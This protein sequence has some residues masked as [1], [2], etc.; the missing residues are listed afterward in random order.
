[1]NFHDLAED[2]KILA[3]MA[4]PVLITPAIRTKL[5]AFIEWTKQCLRCLQHPEFYVFPAQYHQQ[6]LADYGDHVAFLERSKSLAAMAKPQPFKGTVAWQDFAAQLNSF[7]RQ[8]P[9]RYGHPLVYVIQENDD[10]EFDADKNT[11]MQNRYI[12]AAALSG[13][14][15]DS[16]AL[17]VH[18]YIVSLIAGNA[19]AEAAIQTCRAAQCGRTDYK[20]LKAVYEGLA[21]SKLKCLMRSIR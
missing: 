1:M 5:Q 3:K 14:A 15:F 2:V 10:S 7:L 13:P 19:K 6:I 18:T 21:H 16:D 9:G 12:A 11:V 4:N 8:L 17:E 20:A